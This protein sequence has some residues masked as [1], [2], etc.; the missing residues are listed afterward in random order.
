[1]VFHFEALAFVGPRAPGTSRN[2][3]VSAKTIT[4]SVSAP[5]VGAA[6]A[7]SRMSANWA[8][9]TTTVSAE[10]V[11]DGRHE[12]RIW[13]LMSAGDHPPVD[14]FIDEQG[15]RTT[16]CFRAAP[17]REGYCEM[18]FADHNLLFEL[19]FAVDHVADRGEIASAL[20]RKM[21]D[22]RDNTGRVAVPDE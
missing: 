1:M 21:Q 6:T 3:Q 20:L 17:R 18:I 7:Y 8:A 11:G 19:T 22:W 16:Y 10:V 12:I 15:A 13:R 5:P 9:N 4:A 2:H 14:F